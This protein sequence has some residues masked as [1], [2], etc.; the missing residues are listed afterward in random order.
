MRGRVIL[1][2]LC[3]GKTSC[4]PCRRAPQYGQVDFVMLPWQL[5]CGHQ[6]RPCRSRVARVFDPMAGKVGN[7]CVASRC[8]GIYAGASFPTEISRRLQPHRMLFWRRYKNMLVCPRTPLAEIRAPLVLQ[9]FPVIVVACNKFHPLP[10]QR[11]LYRIHRLCRIWSKHFVAV[12]CY[13]KR[14]NDQLQ[15]VTKLVNSPGLC[16]LFG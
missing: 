3:G 5:T 4:I 9:V 1:S 10:L 7:E 8:V 14:M 11:P 15:R 6:R 13:G 16:C 12:T 2:V